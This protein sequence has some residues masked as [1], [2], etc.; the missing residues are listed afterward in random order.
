[1]L[2]AGLVI[3]ERQPDGYEEGSEGEDAPCLQVG[4]VYLDVAVVQEQQDGATAQAG[5]DT[6][7]IGDDI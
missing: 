6:G 5:C 7:G 4:R 3:L 1:M 2:E